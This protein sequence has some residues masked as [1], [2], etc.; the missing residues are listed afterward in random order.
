M[1]VAQ[2]VSHDVALRALTLEIADLLAV[3]RHV[4]KAQIG[5]DGVGFPIPEVSRRSSVGRE[6]RARQTVARSNPAIATGCAAVFPADIPGGG[7]ASRSVMKS[8]DRRIS[9]ARPSSRNRMGPMVTVISIPMSGQLL[10]L[11]Q[12]HKLADGLHSPVWFTR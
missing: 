2:P 9:R 4:S 1:F 8:A 3:A 12:Y 10:Q 11:R 7:A 5:R 6:N